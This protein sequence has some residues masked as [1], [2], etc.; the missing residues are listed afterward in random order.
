M[1]SVSMDMLVLLDADSSVPLT[2]ATNLYRGR[3]PTKT[4]GLCVV[5]V[6]SPG[7][8]PEIA[9]EV[10]DIENPRLQ[11]TVRGDKGD[12]DEAESLARDVEGILTAVRDQLIGTTRY[13]KIWTLIA[14]GSIG[15]D[16]NDRPK[17]SATF[18]VKRRDE[19]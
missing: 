4:K 14:P 13:I 5:L 18:R 9:T 7:E 2:S 1:N 6:D 11:V 8:E 16:S 10:N 12:Y 3:I 15:Y 17:F 19:S